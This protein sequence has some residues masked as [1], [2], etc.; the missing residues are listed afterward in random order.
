MRWGGGFVVG[1]RLVLG[2]GVVVSGRFCHRFHPQLFKQPF[3]E[4]AI[5]LNRT[6][7][8]PLFHMQPYQNA[9]HIFTGWI[10]LQ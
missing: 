9:Y 4:A 6:G 7:T 5:G 2:K 1:E 8:I 10:I 3:F